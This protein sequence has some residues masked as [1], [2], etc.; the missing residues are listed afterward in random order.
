MTRTETCPPGLSFS[1]LWLFDRFS[2]ELVTNVMQTVFM[3]QR[4]VSSLQKSTQRKSYPK[5]TIVHLLHDF[6][7]SVLLHSSKILT[8]QQKGFKPN[9]GIKFHD[10]TDLGQTPWVK[11][12]WCLPR[13][14]NG[15]ISPRLALLYRQNFGRVYVGP[16]YY[17]SPWIIRENDLFDQIMRWTKPR[18]WLHLLSFYFPLLD[19]FVNWFVLIYV[20]SSVRIKVSFN[21]HCRARP[22]NDLN[23]T[24]QILVF[25]CQT[26]SVYITKQFG[27]QPKIF[28]HLSG[29]VRLTPLSDIS[30]IRQTWFIRHVWR[31]RRILCS[32]LKV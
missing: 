15:T 4:K 28:R 32:L 13:I 8:I 21:K 19:A 1:C 12:C 14:S 11:P 9:S 6:W 30:K 24:T 3:W 18:K 26:Y 25:P 5:G 16:W 20:M 22:C 2:L 29:L 31:D 10:F 27:Y 7:F 17:I 23:L